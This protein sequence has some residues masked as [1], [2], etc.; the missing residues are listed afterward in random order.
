MG[1]APS[2]GAS[3]LGVAS[4]SRPAH[5]P[6][7]ARGHRVAVGPIA[8]AASRRPAQPIAI[9]STLG[10]GF[11]LPPVAGPRRAN[12]PSRPPHNP[13]RARGHRVAVGPIAVAASRRPA[14]P[15]AIPSTLGAGF[16][17]PPVA[18][19]RRANDLPGQHT[20]P[21]AR[22]AIR[23]RHGPSRSPALAAQRNRLQF[24]TPWGGFPPPPIAGP[25]RAKGGPQAENGLFQQVSP[26][27][28][29]G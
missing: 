25:R 15:I 11:P 3:M 6:S 9:P 7:R 16:P 2:P 5:N 21:H 28:P 12:G 27:G 4:S 13:S 22:E 23:P 14:Q 29:R 10:A 8:V 24:L 20:T 26:G 1:F 18:G 17:L 19:P